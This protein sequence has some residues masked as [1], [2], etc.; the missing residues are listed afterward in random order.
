MAAARHR[1]LCTAKMAL[2][3]ASQRRAA[4]A[5]M[6]LEHRL[7]LAGRTG[8][9]FGAPPRLQSAARAIHKKNVIRWSSRAFSMAITA[10]AAKFVTSLIWACR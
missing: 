4:L 8:D 7:Q 2:Q 10:C 1:L 5:S 9:D 6:A 3:V